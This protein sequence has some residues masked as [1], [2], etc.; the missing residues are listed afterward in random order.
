[1]RPHSSCNLSAIRSN[2]HMASLMLPSVSAT[3]DTLGQ[4]YCNPSKLPPHIP[5]PMRTPPMLEVPSEAAETNALVAAWALQL[6]S[7]LDPSDKWSQAQALLAG[8]GPPPQDVTEALAQT[9]LAGCTLPAEGG[10]LRGAATQSASGI[11][12]PPPPREATAGSGGGGSSV[13]VSGAGDVSDARSAGS[14]SAANVHVEAEQQ[15]P[16]G[17]GAS[18]AHAAG[19]A[20]DLRCAQCGS[21]G[22]E[23]QLL[24]CSAC[25]GARYCSREC[26]RLHWRAH[27]A[28]CKRVQRELKDG[29]CDS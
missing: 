15:G 8:G 28:D 24:R 22:R 5:G 18:Q 3:M 29:A 7:L 4:V 1:M 2:E 9:T 27:K 11:K 6:L 17:G 26:Q 13:P 10:A 20:G 14:S 19:G 25:K 21:A 12:P 16:R 23:S